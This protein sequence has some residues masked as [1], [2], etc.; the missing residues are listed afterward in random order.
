MVGHI[1]MSF[2][3]CTRYMCSYT[4]Q[5]EIYICKHLLVSCVFPPQVW[6]IL[7]QGFG[8]QDL[9]PQAVELSFE[10]WWENIN[11]RVSG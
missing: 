8:L 5:D 3:Y 4:T 7:L 11:T 6:F 9:A 10:E 2:S 1:G